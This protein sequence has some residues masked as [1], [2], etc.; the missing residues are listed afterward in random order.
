MGQC[1]GNL[2]LKNV[3]P[4]LLNNLQVLLHLLFFQIYAAMAFESRLSM[5]RTDGGN[6]P[7]I[8]A[9]HQNWSLWSGSCLQSQGFQLSPLRSDSPGSSGT[10]HGSETLLV[11]LILFCRFPI[12]GYSVNATTVSGMFSAQAP[13]G[14]NMGQTYGA[15][16]SKF[17]SSP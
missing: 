10:C 7:P 14:V 17:S 15:A 13:T 16:E 6:N 3:C 4:H 12:K 2:H 1:K 11:L 8:Q 9:L 5:R